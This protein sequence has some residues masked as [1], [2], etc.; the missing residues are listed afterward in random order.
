MQFGDLL[1]LA[2]A[3]LRAHKLRSFL[4]M[5]GLVIGVATLITVMTVV[6]GANA[7]VK[8]KI[9]NLGIDVFEVSKTPIVITDFEEFIR[10]RRNKDI[11]VDD[12]EALRE[13]CTSCDAVGAQVSTQMRTRYGDREITDVSVF[14][15]TANMAYIG[16]RTVQRG[17]FFT[18]FEEAQSVPV[19]LLGWDPAEQLFPNIDPIDKVVRA[20]AQELRVI[21]TMERIGSIL[22]Q[23][24][25]NYLIMPLT[26]WLKL[27]GMR[28]SLRLEIKAR[29]EAAFQAA[30]D[31]VRVTLRA[32]RHISPAASKEDFYIA[33][34][35]SYMNLW[36]SIS[37]AFFLVFVMIS[38]ISAVV[39]GIV[40]MNVMLV[41]VTE[42]T[43]EIGVRRACGARR[44]DILRQFLAEALLSCV[45]GGVAG[46]LLGFAAALLLKQLTAFPAT[47]QFWVAALG[48]LFASVIGLFFGIYPASRAARLDPVTALR[49]E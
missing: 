30:Q 4:T 7:Y 14:G 36:R 20:G 39:G 33:T 1:V 25:D 34:P 49:S 45:I 26:L 31:E 18:P 24:Q 41:S 8:D 37:G 43:K 22:G 38:S 47:V 21:G 6:Q 44:N 42:R 48:V 40:I 11:T 27:R 3:N 2:W 19:C 17:R 29:N 15:Q 9:A 35:D 13:R 12:L 23:N 32:R 10:A 5:L 28:R 16:T 46:V